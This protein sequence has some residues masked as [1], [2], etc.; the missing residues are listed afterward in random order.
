MSDD[1]DGVSADDLTQLSVTPAEKKAKAEK[2]KIT[3]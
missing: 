3:R 2:L 1:Y